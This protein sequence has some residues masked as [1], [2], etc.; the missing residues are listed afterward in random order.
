MLR[1]VLTSIAALVGLIAL[2]ILG[3]LVRNAWGW[4]QAAR[5]AQEAPLTPIADL[6]TTR[7]L[8][9]LPLIDFAVE[10]ENLRGEHGVSYLVTTDEATIL[11]D[12]GFNSEQADPSPLLANMERLGVTQAA[13]NAVVI[14]HKHPDH[15]GGLRWW[16]AGAF[17]LGNQQ[18][19]L[20][21]KAI[22][23]PEAMSYPRATP[24][25]ADR[26]LRLA[27][28]VATMGRLPFRE[29]AP[30]NLLRAVGWEQTLA[31]HVADH[32]IVLISG[33]GHPGLRAIVARAE[34]LFDAPVVGVIGGLHYPTATAADMASPIALLQAR[35]PQ[36]VG[37]S[38]HDSSPAAIGAFEAA[39]GAAYRTIAVGREIRFD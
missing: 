18:V 6:G 22:Y 16:Q 12:V 24:I 32:G 34:A 5:A 33:C 7:T 9:I 14:S 4:R 26:P 23:V 39:F 10:G 27:R 29:V 28:G 3:L 38:P 25:I 19:D 30:L 13:I 36:W 1:T 15:V 2:A 35:Q 11:F 21:G 17:S 37:L 20:A 31:V 8:R